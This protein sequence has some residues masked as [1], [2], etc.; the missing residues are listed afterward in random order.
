M[1]RGAIRFIAA[2]AAS[3]PVRGGSSTTISPGQ[4]KKLQSG[5]TRSAVTKRALATPF[6][7]GV[8]DSARDEARLAFDAEKARGAPRERQAEV[9]EPAVE[10]E[11]A[12][13]RL[14]TSANR[15]AVATSS[16]LT[17]ALTCTKSVGWNSSV[18]PSCASD[19]SARAPADRDHRARTA[20]SNTKP[21]Q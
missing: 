12:V 20:G 11:H 3:A 7:V 19:S 16:A 5:C 10:I 6:D 1:R 8:P 9:A 4:P 14:R 21:N 2:T 13:R 17:A 18:T 15:T